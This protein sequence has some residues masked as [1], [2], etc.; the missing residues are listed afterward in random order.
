MLSSLEHSIKAVRRR[1]FTAAWFEALA[2]HLALALFAGGTA[3]LIARVALHWD[4]VPAAWF[5]SLAA[6]APVSAW[7]LARRRIPSRESCATWLDVRGGASGLVVTENELGSSAWSPRAEERLRRSLDVLPEVDIL[8]TLRNVTPAAAFVALA[9]W[10][11]PPQVEVGPP[12]AV[13]DAA[14]ERVEEKLAALEQVLEVEPELAAELDEQL[15]SAKAEAAEGRPE[16]TF[17]ALDR[18]EERLEDQAQRAEQAAHRAQHELASAVGEPNLEDAQ[19]AL[20]NALA[21]MAKAGLE[22]DLPQSLKDELAPG[23]L[24]LPE[25]VQLSSAEL[26]KLAQ[27][28]KGTLDGKLGK[29]AQGKLLDPTAVAKLGQLSLDDFDDTH[30]C[31]ENCT[32]PGGT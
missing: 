3:I 19:A 32:K 28:M 12:P 30:E 22:K 24:S 14:I 25:G 31:D 8:R 15:E 2:T 21:E 4:R 23:T 17:E 26:A 20:E 16:S 27:Q 29:L 9:L 13:A 18:M 10:I 5:A 11:E 1:V 6:V 7:W